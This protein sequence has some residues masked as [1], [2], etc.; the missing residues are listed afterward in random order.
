VTVYVD[1]A[2]YLAAAGF[3]AVVGSGLWG[4][5]GAAR[6][7]V[8]LQVRRWQRR[9][10]GVTQELP[11]GDENTA[12]TTLRSRAQEL[13]WHPAKVVA[14]MAEGEVVVPE[15]VPE[16]VEQ[17]RRWLISIT[18]GYI[19]LA[20]PRH[21]R[22]HL[23]TALVTLPDDDR[24]VAAPEAAVSGTGTMGTAPAIPSAVPRRLT[25]LPFP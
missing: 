19:S 20:V 17:Y 24:R 1:P 5:R 16:A 12:V 21:R 11:A 22:H 10:A 14:R 7:I 25:E 3:L 6:L 4:A 9:F 13:K 23:G 18:E 8:A 2:R 15:Q